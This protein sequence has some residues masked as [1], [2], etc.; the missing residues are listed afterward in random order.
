M[1]VGPYDLS[2]S[3]GYPGQITHPKVK[4][5]ILKIKDLA[6]S[7]NIRLGAFADTVETYQFLVENKFD[8]IAYSVDVN[9]FINGLKKIKSEL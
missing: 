5:E 9:L 6:N 1:F 7:K 2:Q 4:E 8:Y 3:L